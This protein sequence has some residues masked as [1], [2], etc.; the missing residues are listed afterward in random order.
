VHND[1]FTR[2]NFLAFALVRALRSPFL[3]DG[4]RKGKMDQIIDI[5]PLLQE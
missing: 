1:R 2:P 5:G 3:H 4:S